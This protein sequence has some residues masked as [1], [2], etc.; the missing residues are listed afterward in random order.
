MHS[1]FK[2]LEPGRL[3]DR[4]LEL[5]LIERMPAQPSRLF[6]PSYEFEMRK[7]GEGNGVG[8]IRLRIGTENQVRYAGHIGYEVDPPHRGQHF[9]A[10]STL[11]ILPLARAH[12]LP[13]VWLTVDPSN[14]ASRKTCHWLGA[15]FIETV[16]IPQEHNMFE[17]VPVT[18]GAIASNCDK[19]DA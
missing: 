16:E 8:L 6:V 5:V 17:K 15:E 10:R 7:V 12:R 3:V 19:R 2:F 13:E 14:T 18:E 4:D 9:A 1:S 11:L